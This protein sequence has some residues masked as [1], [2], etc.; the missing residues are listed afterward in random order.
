MGKISFAQSL[1][2]GNAGPMCH[3]RIKKATAFNKLTEKRLS[4]FV[5]ILNQ[6]LDFSIVSRYATIIIQL[7]LHSIRSHRTVDHNDFVVTV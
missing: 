5:R 4:P 7:A 2:K 6:I 3:D 1:A